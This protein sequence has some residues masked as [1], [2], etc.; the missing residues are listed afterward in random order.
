M[1]LIIWE[2]AFS[3]GVDA[4]DN[5]H[6]IIASLINHIDE[7]KQHGSD[8]RAI[9]RILK[10]LIGQAVSHFAREEEMMAGVG[11]GELEPHRNEHNVLLQQLEELHSAY[12]A[13]AD[14][15][16][17]RE[18]MELLNFWLVRHILKVDMRYR[19]VLSEE[20]RA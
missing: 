2:D 18:I 13:T 3:V 1:A 12:V 5:D 4:L 14:P 7:A 11:F 10:A 20:A 9:G 19:A 8:E 17:S 15:A 6:I 16:I